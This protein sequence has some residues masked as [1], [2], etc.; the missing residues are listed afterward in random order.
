MSLEEIAEIPVR[1]K[2]PSAPLALC[3]RRN[4]TPPW[5]FEMSPRRAASR[6]ACAP[7]GGSEQCELGAPMT[8]PQSPGRRIVIRARR[9]VK[10]HSTELP[11]AR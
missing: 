5:S 8:T 7:F 1:W 10:L 6:R 11:P 2:K 4:F 3:R 9:R